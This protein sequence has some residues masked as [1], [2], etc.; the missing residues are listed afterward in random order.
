MKRKVYL[1]PIFAVVTLSITLVTAVI[2]APTN[3]NA[4]QVPHRAVHTYQNENADNNKPIDADSIMSLGEQVTIEIAPRNANIETDDTVASDE[5]EPVEDIKKEIIMY[6]TEKDVIAVAKVLYREC[7]GVKSVTE[8]ACV[9]WTI[10]NR[11]D[12]GLG[13]DTFLEVVSYPNA[14]A[15]EYNTPVDDDLYELALDV[16]TRWNLEKNGQTDVGR[17]LPADYEY[18][19]GDGT[20]NHF[21]NAYSGNYDIWDYSLESPYEN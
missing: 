20:H 10:C 13:G 14:F 11:V 8:Q 21:R 19:Y 7:R 15:Y 1:P 3:S 16:L 6:F 17:V 5:S 2:I 12:T 9:A 4:M 18:F